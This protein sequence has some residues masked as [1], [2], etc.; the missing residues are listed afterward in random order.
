MSTENPIA[1]IPAVAEGRIELHNPHTD[2]RASVA[3]AAGQPVNVYYHKATAPEPPTEPEPWGKY[4]DGWPTI[5][6]GKEITLNGNQNN[7]DFGVDVVRNQRFS[8]PGGLG[9]VLTDCQG[10][11]YFIGCDFT[12]SRQG[13]V[14]RMTRD[15]I[16]APTV[17]CIDCL[18]DDNFVPG[19]S[20]LPAELGI[21]YHT[22]KGHG[23]I[24]LYGCG[25]VNSGW[26]GEDRDKDRD[27]T[28]YDHDV[29][30][31]GPVYCDMFDCVS[32][33]PSAQ[34]NKGIAKDFDC[35]R[36]AVLEPAIGFGCGQE[37]QY[38]L[39]PSDPLASA[40]FGGNL[41]YGAGDLPASNQRLGW[42]IV[43]QGAHFTAEGN[44]ICSPE[45]TNENLPAFRLNEIDGLTCKATIRNNTIQGYRHVLEIDSAD[46]AFAPEVRLGN[47]TIGSGTAIAIIKER[48]KGSGKNVFEDVSEVRSLPNV[49]L[50]VD[51]I[52]DRVRARSICSD[53]IIAAARRQLVGG[54]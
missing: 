53:E 11:V 39:R 40:Y 33:R 21:Y 5:P 6:T 26:T 45:S 28:I 44:I 17:Y 3:T 54:A 35:R 8:K 25:F 43:A 51:A 48:R 19:L 10:V 41:I 7:R 32:V 46:R 15:D 18:F 4:G 49:R 37:E 29:Y 30:L 20:G 34:C 22:K 50:D 1:I 12:N 23:F 14:V 38:T 16:T 52:R 31:K 13:L 47:N 2:E 24:G 42:G 9:L 27:P 36:N